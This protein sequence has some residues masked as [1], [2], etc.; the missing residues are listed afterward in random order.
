MGE[1]EEYRN[2]LRMHKEKMCII[3]LLQLISLKFII[4]LDEKT[5]YSR[6]LRRPNFPVFASGV[7]N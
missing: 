6:E 7:I 2:N 1:S 4:R 3:L 5:S